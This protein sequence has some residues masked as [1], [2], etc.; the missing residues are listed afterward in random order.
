MW[1]PGQRGG[2]SPTGQPAGPQRTAERREGLS[3]EQLQ[4]RRGIAEGQVTISQ[5]WKGKQQLASVLR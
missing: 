1:V 4:V 5:G 3:E 2:A